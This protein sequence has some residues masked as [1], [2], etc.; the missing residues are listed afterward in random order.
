MKSREDE[1]MKGKKEG[2]TLEE[3]GGDKR[4]RLEERERGEEEDI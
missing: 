3:G 4:V 1:R 2:S